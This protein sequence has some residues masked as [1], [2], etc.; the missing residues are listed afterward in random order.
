MYSRGD[1]KH[2]VHH[3]FMSGVG[4]LHRLITSGEMV[5]LKQSILYCYFMMTYIALLY[6]VSACEGAGGVLVFTL[7]APILE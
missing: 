7:T 5:F 1:F 3:K 4:G 6:T 2:Q